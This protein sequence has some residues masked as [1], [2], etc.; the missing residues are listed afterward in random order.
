VNNHIVS[1]GKA[2]CGS[3]EMSSDK[4][5][6]CITCL[7]MRAKTNKKVAQRLRVELEFQDAGWLNAKMYEIIN[8]TASP[9]YH[10]MG[11]NIFTSAGRTW[12]Y[13]LKKKQMREV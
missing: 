7:K 8:I 11:R 4:Y 9:A 12:K 13:N 2:I 3:H 6:D 10:W 5:V 1:K